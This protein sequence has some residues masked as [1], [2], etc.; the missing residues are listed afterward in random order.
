MLVKSP[1]LKG[2]G[3]IFGALPLLDSQEST[4]QSFHYTRI[5]QAVKVLPLV[6]FHICIEVDKIFDAESN[7][8]VFFDS[9]FIQI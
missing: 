6:N 8:L 7:K 4:Q 5:R 9:S 2:L 3:A 1:C